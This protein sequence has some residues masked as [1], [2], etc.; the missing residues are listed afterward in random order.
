MQR[1]ALTY[2][3]LRLWNLG[4]ALIVPAASDE[5][6]QYGLCVEFGRLDGFL[7]RER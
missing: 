6:L 5:L 3:S 2:D 4:E 7:R 1:R